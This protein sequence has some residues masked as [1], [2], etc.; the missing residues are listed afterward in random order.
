MKTESLGS[1]FG[2]ILLLV[3]VAAC[4]ASDLAHEVRQVFES[5]AHAC[6]RGD[7]SAVLAL[8]EED[9]RVIWLGEPEEA[10]G[11]E[12]LARLVTGGCRP[13]MEATIELD[14]LEVRPI[15]ESHAAAVLHGE[16]EM[17][18]PD[19]QRRASFRVRLTQL[20][21]RRSGKWRILVEHASI[22]LPPP[23]RREVP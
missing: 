23:R 7:V 1:A 21:R 15:G 4:E 19:G 11:R 16:Y 5:F 8:Y 17:R 10:R 18:T 9:A 22:G 20:L 14:D 2:A 12:A 3:A 13:E 6:E